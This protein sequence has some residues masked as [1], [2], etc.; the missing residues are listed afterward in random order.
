MWQIKNWECLLNINNVNKVGY[1]DSACFLYHNN[2]NYIITSNSNKN[3]FSEPIKIYDFEGK[4]IK[5]IIHSNKKTYFIDI[6]YDYNSNINNNNIYIITGSQNCIRTFNYNEN[7]LY[8]KYY[9]YINGAHICVV[10]YK[11]N[12]ELKLIESC[13]DGNIRIWDFHS[14]NLLKKIKISAQFIFGICLWN[15]NYIYV[16]CED[17]TIKLI[18]INKGLIVKN[19]SGHNDDVL[20]INKIILPNYGECLISQG[21]KNDQIKLWVK[22]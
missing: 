3:G 8:K 13:D 10:V 4:K 1:L 7:Q 21:R 16:G 20:S 5:E 19:L 15:N 18:E 11:N 17:K 14:A 22:N 9:D 2:N 12:K 6:Y